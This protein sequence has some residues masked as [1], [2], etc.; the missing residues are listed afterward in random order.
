MVSPV[1]IG[2][3]VTS[4]QARSRCGVLQSL[5]SLQPQILRRELLLGQIRELC[6]TMHGRGVQRLMLH[7]LHQIV[8]E[9]GEPV[10]KLLH[11]VV[12]LAELVHETLESLL[13]SHQGGRQVVRT[14]MAGTA[15]ANLVGDLANCVEDGRGRSGSE[16]EE[17]ETEHE[18]SGRRHGYE[19]PRT[20]QQ[21]LPRWNSD[22]L[23]WQK[24]EMTS[25][26]P[27]AAHGGGVWDR[28]YCHFREAYF[29]LVYLGRSFYKAW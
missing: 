22:G 23:L 13:G 17:R 28:Y 11:G 10:L 29:T 26:D 20:V 4:R 6:D 9:D 19:I 25:D 15:A 5:R 27:M 7:G 12:H 8:L 2:R 21:L 1:E 18:G 24:R 14:A 3:Q 16:E